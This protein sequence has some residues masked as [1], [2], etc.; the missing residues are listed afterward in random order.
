MFVA[1]PLFGVAIVAIVA[2][3]VDDRSREEEELV[4][5]VGLRDRR[6]RFHFRGGL[7]GREGR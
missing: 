2:I 1:A 3:V 4:S 7:L 5:A 6:W